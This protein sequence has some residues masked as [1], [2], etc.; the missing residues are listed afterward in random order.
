[1]RHCT[2]EVG[3]KMTLEQTQNAQTL[4]PK[5]KTTEGVSCCAIT[6]Q[7]RI[8]AICG[9]APVQTLPFAACSQS[10]TLGDE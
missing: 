10:K 8:A 1:M 5:L 4:A 3:R 2:R 9:R 7:P 6:Q